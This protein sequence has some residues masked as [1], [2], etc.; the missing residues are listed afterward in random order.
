MATKTI[1]HGQNFCPIGNRAINKTDR[2]Y[3]ANCPFCKVPLPARNRYLLVTVD[4]NGTVV[5]SELM[6]EPP[7]WKRTP[8]V[9]AVALLAAFIIM[10]LFADLS[11]DT[12][13][14]SGG[15]LSCN[16]TVRYSVDGTARSVDITMQN[17]TGNT[18]QLSD[19]SLPWDLD[20]GAM[21]CGDFVYLSAQNQGDTGTV[22]CEISVG[23]A[24]LETATSSGSYV[25]ASC[26][27]SVD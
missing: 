5:S 25:I 4:D 2:L 19:V 7:I 13:P 3:G 20:V 23:S 8:V 22:T 14:S 17:R 6:P 12:G 24:V 21:G 27:G 18:E 9:M 16:R 15:S 1:T 26:S 11:G 10:F